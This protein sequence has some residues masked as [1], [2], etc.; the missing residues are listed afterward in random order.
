LL[1]QSKLCNVNLA[2]IDRYASQWKWQ[3]KVYLIPYF[4]MK[5]FRD[6]FW[7]KKIIGRQFLTYFANF[8]MTPI[9]VVHLQ[10]C[11]ENAL[12]PNLLGVKCYF[13]NMIPYIDRNRSCNRFFQN[14][15]FSSS[16]YVIVENQRQTCFKTKRINNLRVGLNALANRFFYLNDKIP[17]ILLNNNV[18]QYKIAC[19]KIIFNIWLNQSKIKLIHIKYYDDDNISIM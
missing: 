16:Y 5:I 7:E 18:V 13:K 1:K 8:L 10:F 15:H 17:L 11:T 14:N 4:K 6:T 9:G 2:C 19:K 3:G 12:W